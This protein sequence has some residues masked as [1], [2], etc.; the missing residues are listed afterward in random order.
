MVFSG[1]TLADR[2]SRALAGGRKITGRYGLAKELWPSGWT[3]ID[4]SELNWFLNR[5]I[6]DGRVIETKREVPGANEFPAAV[7]YEYSLGR[8]P[9]APPE[10]VFT[11]VKSP[12]GDTWLVYRDGKLVDEYPC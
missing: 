8:A 2:I 3:M 1:K 9:T 10:P 6:Q 7:E 5:M 11:R 4:M 12:F